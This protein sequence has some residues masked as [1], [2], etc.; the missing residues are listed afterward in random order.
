MTKQDYIDREKRQIEIND[1]LIYFL[2][3]FTDLVRK[4]DGKVYNRKLFDEYNEQEYGLGGEN[5]I[6]YKAK[7]C[8]AD[9]SIGIPLNI[10][11][12]AYGCYIDDDFQQR[13]DYIDLRNHRHRVEFGC[14][15]TVPFVNA[16]GRYDYG[17]Y[18]ELAN[19]K[20]GE[21]RE[22]TSDIRCELSMLDEYEDL[23]NQVMALVSD[24]LD[25]FPKRL[26]HQCSIM[27]SGGH[28]A[29]LFDAPRA[30]EEEMVF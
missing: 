27:I 28:S 11:V 9:P 8:K 20:I 17:R 12:D 13:K 3:Y 24:T 15:D 29:Q 5:G 10:E 7:A 4:Y 16:E 1:A 18:V 30:D 6:F 21:L 19:E 2:G 23:H 26:R 22:Q 14:Y 25:K